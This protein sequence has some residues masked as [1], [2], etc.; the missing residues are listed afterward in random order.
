MSKSRPCARC[1]EPTTTRSGPAR[2]AAC[3][4]LR[5]RLEDYRRGTATERGYGTEHFR[6]RREW[7][8][9]VQRGEC[10]C[11][12]PVCHNPGGR[13]IAPGTPWDLDHTA[14]RTGYRGPSHARCN[15][16][17][18]GRQPEPVTRHSRVW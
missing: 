13:W 2:C 6:R 16:S 8:A 10:Y 4:E 15:R 17:T 7:D 1:G 3:K 11:A 14:D 12:A 5:E 9:K 18:T